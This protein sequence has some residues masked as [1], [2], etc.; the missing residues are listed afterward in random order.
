MGALRSEGLFTD[1][2]ESDRRSLF[3]LLTSLHDRMH[4]GND[5]A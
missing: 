5:D 1:L 2:T 3:R 4:K